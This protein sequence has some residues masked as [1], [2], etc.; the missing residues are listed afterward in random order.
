M[1][2]TIDNSLKTRPT[3]RFNHRLRNCNSLRCNMTTKVIDSFF[4]LFSN[5]HGEINFVMRWAI[6][7][8]VRKH[9]REIVDFTNSTFADYWPWLLNG[10]WIN[11]LLAH[12]NCSTVKFQTGFTNWKQK[13]NFLDH[14]QKNEKWPF[15]HELWKIEYF[16]LW[17]LYFC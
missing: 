4:P 2:I 16:Q 7:N 3:K 1:K 14:E 15:E 10:D 6:R 9:R 12:F 13:S 5:K 11:R 17:P 8:S